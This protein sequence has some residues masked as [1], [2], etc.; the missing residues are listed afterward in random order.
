MFTFRQ[1]LVTTFYVV[2]LI[3]LPQINNSSFSLFM[4][5][6]YEDGRTYLRKDT[7]I[8]CW[9]TVH[10]LLQLSIGLS[11]IV[12]WAIVFPI[13]IYLSINKEQDKLNNKQN[14]KLY[15]IFYVG[16][17]DSSFSWEIIWMNI[18][19]L[20]LIVA[21]TFFNN[22]MYIYKVIIITSF[23]IGEYWYL[24][25]FLL[26]YTCIEV[27]ALYGPSVQQPRKSWQHR[28]CKSNL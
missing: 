9:E 16:L 6:P 14:L 21:A 22:Q 17:T 26:E 8:A 19:K 12:I 3:W 11:F 10:I 25:T 20:S 24:C 4:C 23:N 13:V 15:G 7:A 27:V 5:D 18:R 28:I 2:V 1:K